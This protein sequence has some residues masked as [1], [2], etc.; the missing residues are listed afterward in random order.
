MILKK[1]SK[2]KNKQSLKK[3]IKYLDDNQTII[4]I[5]YKIINCKNYNEINANTVNI[6]Q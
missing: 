4:I 5:C 2:R 1:K 6:N 3:E